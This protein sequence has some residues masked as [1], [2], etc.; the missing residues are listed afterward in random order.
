[1]ETRAGLGAG[2]AALGL[3]ALLSDS[4]TAHRAVGVAWLGAASGRLTG[5]TLD[6]PQTDPIHW[7]SLAMELTGGLVGVLA[8]RTE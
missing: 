8:S 2:Y 7:G 5:M 6:Q 3:W 4:P 1:M